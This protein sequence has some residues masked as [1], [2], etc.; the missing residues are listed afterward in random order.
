M[1]DVSTSVQKAIAHNVCGARPAKL[2]KADWK[3]Y[4]FIKRMLQIEHKLAKES[5]ETN[6]GN[7]IEEAKAVT[8]HFCAAIKTQ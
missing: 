5:A 8:E 4:A 2:S 7:V 6:G 1:N 3:P